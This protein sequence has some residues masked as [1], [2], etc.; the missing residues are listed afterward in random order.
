MSKRIN[1]EYSNIKNKVNSR[2]ENNTPGWR[3]II[4]NSY[5]KCEACGRTIRKNQK[6]LWH[7]DTKS[8]M[9]FPEECKLW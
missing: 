6:M 3:T 4:S 7:I 9:H 2:Q 5:V 8:V 1:W